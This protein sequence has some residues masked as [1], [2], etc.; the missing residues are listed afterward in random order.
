MVGGGIRYLFSFFVWNR[1]L[2]GSVMLNLA[3]LNLV[4][5]INLLH[6]MP[7]GTISVKYWRM[8]DLQFSISRFE[9]KEPTK[10][11][12]CATPILDCLKSPKLFHRSI[13]VECDFFN[14]FVLTSR[15]SGFP[16]MLTSFVSDPTCD[17]WARSR[18]RNLCQAQMHI[19]WIYTEFL[20]CHFHVV[21]K[22]MG[23]WKNEFS[24]VT[25]C[26]RLWSVHVFSGLNELR[27]LF[28]YRK[29]WNIKEIRFTFHDILKNRQRD[30]IK[31][32][33]WCMLMFVFGFEKQIRDCGSGGV[34]GG[35]IKNH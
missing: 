3:R 17:I 14:F 16:L 15:R 33:W 6:W 29:R 32:V 26:N 4:L 8:E 19:H 11:R 7:I 5:C 31:I 25:E 27:R 13:I 18:S 24:F 34:L 30:E 1:R 9:W 2:S 20:F 22:E 10:S 28:W 23:K 35:R 12:R 21:E